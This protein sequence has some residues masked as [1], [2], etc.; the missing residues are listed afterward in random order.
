M[1]DFDRVEDLEPQPY[2]ITRKGGHNLCKRYPTEESDGD[3]TDLGSFF[4]WFEL[5]NDPIIRCTR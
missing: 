3:V 2:R 5:P 4:N 1:L